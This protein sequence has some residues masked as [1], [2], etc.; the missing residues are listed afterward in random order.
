MRPCDVIH[1]KRQTMN[2]M[3]LR[4]RDT[5]HSG[6]QQE[7]QD[8]STKDFGLEYTFCLICKILVNTADILTST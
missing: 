4:E 6:A 7:R 3:T 5:R 1:N 2:N 8:L